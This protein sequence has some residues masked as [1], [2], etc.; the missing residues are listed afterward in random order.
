MSRLIRTLLA[1]AIISVAGIT[2]LFWF[3]FRIYVPQDQ[4]LVLI[5]KTGS[6]LASNQKVATEPG[7][8]GI[9]REALGPGRYF[10]NPYTWSFERHDLVEIAAG[11]P[12]TWEWVHSLDARQ[13][14]EVRAETFK[15]R[16]KFPEV[17]VLVRRTGSTDNLVS[18]GDIGE[19]MFEKHINFIW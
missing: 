10:R 11:D 7:E 19:R 14:S 15:F 1:A 5:R 12:K 6:A 9:Q 3:T 4:C 18:A 13:R 16:G 17:G 8:K 2:A